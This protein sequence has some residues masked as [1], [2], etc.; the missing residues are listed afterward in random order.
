MLLYGVPGGAA[1]L[2]PCPWELAC[3]ELSVRRVYFP[4]VA[5]PAVPGVEL[6]G[7]D[8]GAPTERSHG[9]GGAVGR[10]GK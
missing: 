1:V 4:A 5:A 9:E 10:V 8:G 6:C 3:F 2:Y 7:L